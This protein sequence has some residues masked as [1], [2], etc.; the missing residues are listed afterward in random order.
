MKWQNFLAATVAA[1]AILAPCTAQAQQTADVDVVASLE[2][3]ETS[4]T[5]SGVRDMQFGVVTIPDTSRAISNVVCSYDL[6]ISTEFFLT[7]RT[8]RESPD[9]DNPG[10]GGRTLSGCQFR[11]EA[12]SV[13]AVFEITCAPNIMTNY[14]ITWTDSTADPALNF[15]PVPVRPAALYV[16]GT[17]T[18]LPDAPS[19]SASAGAVACPA[20]GA[21]DVQVGGT[22]QVGQTANVA[23]NLSVGSVSL[24]VNY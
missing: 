18:V 19:V 1:I 5:V 24:A 4:L 16:G 7:G 6:S 10:F 3:A 23:S 11:A 14:Q 21:I 12:P 13:G 8:V 20:G 17:S 9:F 22:L 15:V 2:V